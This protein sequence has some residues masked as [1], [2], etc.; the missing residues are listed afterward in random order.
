M[1]ANK[2]IQAVYKVTA[3]SD[4]FLLAYVVQRFLMYDG[5]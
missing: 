3:S 2:I 1:V 5:L 4:E